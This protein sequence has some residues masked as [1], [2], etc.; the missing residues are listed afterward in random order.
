M[1]NLTAFGI[2]EE[3][4][5]L[6]IIDDIPDIPTEIPDE[7]EEESSDGYVDEQEEKGD[8]NAKFGISLPPTYMGHE[9]NK[10]EENC[11]RK[12]EEVADELI[13]DNFRLEDVEMVEYRNAVFD[14]YS[15]IE[16]NENT[17]I[18]YKRDI[19]CIEYENPELINS[20]KTYQRLAFRAKADGDVYDLSAMNFNEAGIEF[21]SEYDGEFDSLLV[22]SINK[23]TEGTEGNFNE[24]Y[25]NG[26]I[27]ENAANMQKVKEGDIVEWRYAE[28]TDG[29]CGGVPDFN[30]IKSL[31]DYSAIIRNGYSLSF[32]GR[33]AAHAA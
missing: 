33:S 8:Y 15:N 9:E 11:S 10:K 7:E 1:E 28:E 21:S 4:S 3:L 18:D 20:Q 12:N 23:R 16:L 25:L 24:F 5:E 29:S 13:L 14:A 19:L 32:R 6:Y 31:L 2:S 17:L 22:T 26:E 27:G 30:Q